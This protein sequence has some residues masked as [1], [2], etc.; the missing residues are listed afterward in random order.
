MTKAPPE[1][2]DTSK[3]KQQKNRIKFGSY[4]INL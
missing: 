1:A 4:E 3:K 2:A